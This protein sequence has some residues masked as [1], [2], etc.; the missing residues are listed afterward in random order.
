[1]LEVFH[2]S[3]SRD[4]HLLDCNY[5][6]EKTTFFTPVE[7]TPSLKDL[8]KRS[9]AEYVGIIQYDEKIHG[10]D[11][12]WRVLQVLNQP[13]H[14]YASA[15]GLSRLVKHG[16]GKMHDEG[17]WFSPKNHRPALGMAPLIF[18][19]SDAKLLGA[20][21]IFLHRQAVL[22]VL[23]RQDFKINTALNIRVS[24]MLTTAGKHCKAISVPYEKTNQFIAHLDI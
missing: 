23:S 22:N 17:Y 7:D 8:L 1:M 19:I 15:V 9:E 5:G 10:F 21:P 2:F 4:I 3:D 24:D 11:W 18:P 14:N 20:G 12:D 13:L 6:N 16:E